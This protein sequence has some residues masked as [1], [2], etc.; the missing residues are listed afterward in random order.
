M[1]SGDHA[2]VKTKPYN[3]HGNGAVGEVDHVDASYGIYLR[4]SNGH[5]DYFNHDD[6]TPTDDPVSSCPADSKCQNVKR[7]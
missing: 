1:E 4:F 7:T 6:V 5:V 2:R 3:W